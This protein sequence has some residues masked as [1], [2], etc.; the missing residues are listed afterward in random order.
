MRPYRHNYVS[1]FT[2]FI[3]RYVQQHPAVQQEQRRGRNIF[4]DRDVDLKELDK[5]RADSVGIKS[6]YYE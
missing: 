2:E 3:D 6:Y 4:W 5:E 1:E